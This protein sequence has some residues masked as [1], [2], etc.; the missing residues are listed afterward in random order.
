[1]EDDSLA[2]AYD[3]GVLATAKEQSSALR[4]MED[5]SLVAR[6]DFTVLNVDKDSRIMWYLR[7]YELGSISI[8]YLLLFIAR[9]IGHNCRLCFFLTALIALDG[10]MIDRSYRQGGEVAMANGADV[11]SVGQRS[12]YGKGDSLGSPRQ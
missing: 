8:L 1:M 3:V 12:S 11:L 6:C 7:N 2:T 9:F 4:L 10:R 5:D